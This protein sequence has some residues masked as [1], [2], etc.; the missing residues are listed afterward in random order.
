MERSKKSHHGRKPKLIKHRILKLEDLKPIRPE[1]SWSPRQKLRVL[2]FLYH[3]QIPINSTIRNYSTAEYRALTQ[4]EASEI[5][6]VPQ[7]TISEWVGKQAQIEGISSRIARSPRNITISPCQWPKLESHLYNRGQGQGIRTGWFRMHS[8]A[9][10]R[11]L[12]PAASYVTCLAI[13]DP[14]MGGFEDLSDAI[15]SAFG[16]S[17][18][19]A[20]H[21]PADCNGEERTS[22]VW[23]QGE[24]SV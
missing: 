20:Q 15:E 14:P 11:D 12:H 13:S 23:V 8:L 9:I 4:L 2:V 22:I 3:H 16:V 24:K 21:I 10:F 18:K 19:K 6:G 5:Y 17:R 1:R 7:R